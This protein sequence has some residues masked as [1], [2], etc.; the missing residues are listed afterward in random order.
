MNTPASFEL[1]RTK[2][3]VAGALHLS[4]LSRLLAKLNTPANGY[5][6]AINYHQTIPRNAVNFEGHLLTY[7]KRFS[8][9]TASDL[10]ILLTRGRWGHDKPGLLISFD[11]G[12]KSNYDIAAPLLEKHGFVGWFFVPV[13]F[14]DCPPAAQREYADAHGM[15]GALVETPAADGRVAM[16]WIELRDLVH[17]GHV[18]GCHTQSHRRLGTSLSPDEL[19]AEIA[20]VKTTM[21]QRLGSPV[22]SFC[23]VG[24]EDDSYSAEAAR[25]I[26]GSD[27]QFAFQTNAGLTTGR[28]HP[29]QINRTNIEDRWP[30]SI[31]AFQLS[32]L[33]D[34]KYAAKRERIEQ[35]TRT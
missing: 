34:R 10:T 33:T 7:R 26:A 17:R 18:V 30:L 28:T 4:G 16:N 6:R 3:L 32:G 23:W 20:D 21:E 35:L 29:L 12:M 5:V 24:G 27:Y 14:I 25:V 9:V 1:G 2:R 22:G 13:G 11:D 8:C 31:V 19:R 15:P